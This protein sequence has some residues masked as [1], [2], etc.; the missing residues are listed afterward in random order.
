MSM[1]TQNTPNFLTSMNIPDTTPTPRTSSGRWHTRLILGAS[2]AFIGQ[3]L[4]GCASFS[5]HMT[6]RPTAKGKTEL[7]ANVDVLVTRVK[8][9][10]E[11]LVAPVP[12]ISLRYGFSDRADFGGKVSLSKAGG[13]VNSRIALIKSEV[14]DLAIVPSAGLALGSVTSDETL[15]PLVSFGIPIL[16]DIRL[17]D[18]GD[19]VLGAKLHAH[20]GT[21]EGENS[22]P[23]DGTGTTTDGTG[24]NNETPLGSFVL[25]P[26]WV[27]G[28]NLELSDNFAIMPEINVLF[29]Y[30]PEENRFAKPIF[31]GGIGFTFGI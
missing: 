18:A 29:P 31:Q 16:A 19:L 30:D 15:G 11:L 2:L 27:V 5:T 20:F 26:G 23:S 1:R 13:E 6:A 25:Y 9:R 3:S 21:I 8:D 17:G 7:G 24:N 28:L 22:N 10:K 14:F 12:E 4:T